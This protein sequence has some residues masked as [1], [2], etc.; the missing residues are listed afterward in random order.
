MTDEDRD[1]I[2]E[3]LAPFGVDLRDLHQ[4]LA[5]F[6]EHTTD[7]ELRRSVLS[8]LVG[9]LAAC[10]TGVSGLDFGAILDEARLFRAGWRETEDGDWTP[11]E[12]R[13]NFWDR[14]RAL[15]EQERRDLSGALTEAPEEA[16]ENRGPRRIYVASSWRN[17]LQPGI[18]AVLRELGHEVYDFRAPTAGNKGFSWSAIDPDWRSWTPEQYRQGLQHPIAKTGHDLD[19]TAL[20]ACDACV[21]VR[22][23]GTSASW[24]L[25][26][27]MGKKKPGYILQL[28]QEEPE[29][30]FRNARI[31]TTMDELFDAFETGRVP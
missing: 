26:Y 16:P 14:G 1:V 11:P 28:G 23:C 7:P 2:A 12:D 9:V 29:L 19:M 25:G 18:V 8:C 4:G 13:R 21:L 15:A 24:E 31:L 6:F 5:D 3:L 27:A 30:M 10:S 20:R 17:M 22:P